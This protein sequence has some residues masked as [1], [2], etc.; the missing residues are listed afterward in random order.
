M[1]VVGFFEVL[2]EVFFESVLVAVVVETV[3]EQHV[4]QRF[5][6]AV[7]ELPAA[8]EVVPHFIGA[9]ITLDQEPLDLR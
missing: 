3:V 4:L 5:K 6:T 8:V 2:L 1:L 7:V 9:L